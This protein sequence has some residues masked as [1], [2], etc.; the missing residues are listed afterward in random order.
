MSNALVSSSFLKETRKTTIL[1]RDNYVPI[2]ED[3]GTDLVCVVP[4]VPVVCILYRQPK[5][6]C[7]LPLFMETKPPKPI[8]LP[9]PLCIRP[10]DVFPRIS[11]M[12]KQKYLSWNMMN[13]E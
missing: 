11:S 12:N 10:T 7:S 2:F 13:K 9:F 1:K 5:I 6:W 3:F 4:T 8:T